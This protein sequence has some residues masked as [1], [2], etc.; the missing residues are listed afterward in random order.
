LIPLNHWHGLLLRRA[1]EK[2]D[3]SKLAL[4]LAP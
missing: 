4:L 3:W 2:T 1:P